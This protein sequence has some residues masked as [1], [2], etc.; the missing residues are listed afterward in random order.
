MMQQTSLQ[1]WA[2]IK[3]SI[4]QRQTQVFQALVACGPMTNAEIAQVLGL[5][6]NCVTGRTREL[7]KRGLVKS[8][9]VWCCSV[10]K[11]SAIAWDVR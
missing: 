9:C 7:V 4:N 2:E 6:I 10:T 8:L 11:H 3:S 1:A 5:P